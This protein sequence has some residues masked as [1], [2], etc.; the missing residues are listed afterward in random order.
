MK[1][2][3]FCVANKPSWGVVDGDE[4]I[5]LGDG[6][7][8]QFPDLRSVIAGQAFGS[9]A[10]AFGAAPRYRL[11]DIDWLPVIGNPGKIICV[12]V[13]YHDHRREMGR[14][15]T[16]MPTI[17][18]RFA[19]SQIG[20]TSNIVR[21]TVSSDL[22]YEGELAVIIG[23]TGR[24]ITRDD[25]M[26]YVAGYAC[27]NDATVRDWQRH[28]HQWI[29]GKNFPGTGAF[30]PWMVTADEIADLGALRLTTRLNGEIMQEA[31]ID[32]LIFDVPQLIA[33][34]SDFTQLEPGDVIVS[35]TPGG[36]GF[37]RT[38]PVFMK[39]GDVVEVEITGVGCLRNGI[40]QES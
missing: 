5:D 16:E 8:T 3:S 20:H 32:Q 29:P 9:L 21:P 27:Y 15:E 17:F 23:K 7:G 39:P 24:H 30:G 34:C 25:A 40:V 37:K 6:P 26:G 33:Y 36:V 2:A 19:N 11:T 18:A 1:L 22:D 14:A 12:G 31:G 28:T 13:N 10:E 38:P 35:G 4:V